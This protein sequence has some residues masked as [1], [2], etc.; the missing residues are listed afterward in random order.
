MGFPL[1]TPI[2]RSLA[3]LAMPANGFL[4]PDNG[5]PSYRTRQWDFLLTCHARKWVSFGFDMLSF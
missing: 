1:I 2:N 5:F 3:M 4:L